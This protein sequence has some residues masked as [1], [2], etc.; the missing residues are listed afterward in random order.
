MDEIPIFKFSWALLCL[1]SQLSPG[2]M[3]KIRPFNMACCH[4]LVKTY[5]DLWEEFIT[6]RTLPEAHKCGDDSLCGDSWYQLRDE[7]LRENANQYLSACS[8]KRDVDQLRLDLLNRGNDLAKILP[9]EIVQIVVTL[10]VEALR[11]DIPDHFPVWKEP[12]NN[13]PPVLR[14]F[15]TGRKMRLRKLF[16]NHNTNDIV[17]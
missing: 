3:L 5:T 15:G 14:S 7:E 17:S 12:H 10:I 6:T 9:P 8:L 1:R 2:K 16:F 4:N 11:R 13:V